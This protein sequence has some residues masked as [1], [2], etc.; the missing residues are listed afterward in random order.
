MYGSDRFRKCFLCLLL[1]SR[2][3]ESISG[4]T[5][6]LHQEGPTDGRWRI[7]YVILRCISWKP[8]VDFTILLMCCAACSS[9]V[10][11]SLKEGCAS[12]GHNGMLL[13]FLL[14]CVK[15]MW[16][17]ETCWSIQSIVQISLAIELRILGICNLAFSGVCISHTRA[18]LLSLCYDSYSYGPNMDVKT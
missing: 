5:M 18:F 7:L 16:W 14:A 6:R 13:R 2:I 11:R 9:Q 8:L 15:S 17:V 12:V 4:W 10:P 3:F 1:Q